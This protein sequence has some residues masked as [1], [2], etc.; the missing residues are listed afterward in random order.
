MIV[1]QPLKEQL[2]R[3][4][5]GHLLNEAAK[6]GFDLTDFKHNKFIVVLKNLGIK[7]KAV[8]GDEVSGRKEHG[9]VWQ[10][11]GIRIVTGNNPITGEYHSQGGEGK[12]LRK[13]EKNY[14]SYIG[15][16][17]KKDLVL[18]TAELINKYASY[19]KREE[20]GRRSYI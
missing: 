11:P 17:G 10:G 13:A 16:E 4:G 2:K 19:I 8:R 15:I 14:A 7:P 3:I 6:H 20:P 9:W 5:G 1:K 12:P 18:K